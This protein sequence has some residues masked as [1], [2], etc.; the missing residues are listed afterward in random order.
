MFRFY[1]K[2]NRNQISNQTKKVSRIEGGYWFSEESD[3]N[4]VTYKVLYRKQ[5][6]PSIYVEWL[7]ELNK[8]FMETPCWEQEEQLWNLI[9]SDSNC[10]HWSLGEF[11]L[12]EI[13]QKF[14]S[15]P[16]EL[17]P[18]LPGWIQAVS[19][20]DYE[21]MKK[22]FYNFVKTMTTNSQKH[23]NH[24]SPLKNIPMTNQREQQSHMNNVE[25]SSQQGQHHLRQSDPYSLDQKNI[26]QKQYQ[27][28]QGGL[29]SQNPRKSEVSK[30]YPRKQKLSGNLLKIS[31]QHQELVVSSDLPR[32][33]M[34]DPTL[35]SIVHKDKQVDLSASPPFSNI[36]PKRKQVRQRM[37]QECLILPS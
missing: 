3:Q 11:E 20:L 5:V 36:Q 28:L 17:P 13:S 27:K 18:I 29:V 2:T 19:F 15:S 30:I 8:D 7:E 6:E 1:W 24:L 14:Y 34:I 12:I 9:Y 33:L 32:G 10:Y 21:M 26:Y 23:L 16:I 22:E 4:L 25:A 31:E 35:D 37:F